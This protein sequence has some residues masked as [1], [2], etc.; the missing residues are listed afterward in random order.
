M[1]ISIGHNDCLHAD[2]VWVL[3][4]PPLLT[5][6][7]CYTVPL[8]I[9]VTHSSISWWETS[10]GRETGRAERSTVLPS[11]L[12][13]PT[14][15]HSLQL[16]HLTHNSPLFIYAWLLIAGYRRS[17]GICDQNECMM[18]TS[19]SSG[20]LLSAGCKD[21]RVTLYH[22]CICSNTWISIEQTSNAATSGCITVG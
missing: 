8:V 16:I 4:S 9:R 3:L 11:L 21:Y 6:K 19:A 18:R 5:H 13:H 20:S 14:L 22:A 1:G 12:M 10:R 2:R 15:L 17:F 7:H